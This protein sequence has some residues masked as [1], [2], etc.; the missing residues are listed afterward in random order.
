MIGNTSPAGT[1]FPCL[2]NG[3]TPGLRPGILLFM[4]Q[5]LFTSI[6]TLPSSSYWWCSGN[7]ICIPMDKFRLTN[8]ISATSILPYM[9]GVFGMCTKRI[10]KKQA[11]PT[12]T[13]W[14]EPF[15]SYS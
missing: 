2:I 5:L 10:R 1:S 4:Q 15:R 6:R 14:K 7:I 8:G 11:F 9:H 13:S 3:N 12:G